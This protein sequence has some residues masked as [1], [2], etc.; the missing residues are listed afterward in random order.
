MKKI[1]FLFPVLCLMILF[2]ACQKN[3]TTIDDQAKEEKVTLT[4]DYILKNVA[5]TDAKIRSLNEDSY[6]RILVVKDF[7]GSIELPLIFG[8]GDD[9]FYDDGTKNDL[10][11]GDG[12]FTSEASY[13]HTASIP[14]MADA[15]ERSV[16]NSP[17]TSGETFQHTEALAEY[18]P[19]GAQARGPEIT[20]GLCW[21]PTECWC[22]AC[23]IA[24]T[25][26]W[27]VRTNA[28]ELEGDW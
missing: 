10:I 16:I 23:A 18:F 28:A 12:V 5:A 20:F 9:I 2:T 25:Y 6:V 14:Y 4:S 22:L 24:D 11:A 15:I 21:C 13:E 26:C 1:N 8:M 3:Q 17:I 7:D 19:R 27:Y